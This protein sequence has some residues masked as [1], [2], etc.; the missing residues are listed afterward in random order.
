MMGPLNDALVKAAREGLLTKPHQ[1]SEEDWRARLAA[2]YP[3]L[4]P[5]A[6]EAARADAEALWAGDQDDFGV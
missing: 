3:D 4:T 6:L 1:V 5:E 2:L